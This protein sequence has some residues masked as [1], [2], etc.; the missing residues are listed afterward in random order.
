[1]REKAA[2]VNER[3]ED[4]IK[5]RFVEGLRDRALAAEAYRKDYEMERILRMA[6]R[7]EAETETHTSKQQAFMPWATAAEVS[8][9]K[10]TPVAAAVDRFE[11]RAASRQR[12][13]APYLKPGGE[14][15]RGRSNDQR[16]PDCGVNKH[17]GETCPAVGKECF[18]CNKAGH[19]RHMCRAG[20]TVNLISDQSDAF[21]VRRE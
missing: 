7:M 12:Q 4:M 15:W 19:F 13:N 5:S 17:R 18:K 8:T 11:Q 20:G 21:K 3:N 16:C 10:T 14:Q 6:A 1:M 2:E 9:Q